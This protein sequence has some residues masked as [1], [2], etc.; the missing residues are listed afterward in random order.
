MASHSGKGNQKTTPNYRTVC[1]LTMF[2]ATITTSLALCKSLSSMTFGQR[3]SASSYVV[4]ARFSYKCETR[5]RG[6]CSTTH[7]RVS[8]GPSV[9]PMPFIDVVQQA[10]GSKRRLTDVFN[11]RRIHKTCHRCHKCPGSDE[12]SPMCRDGLG[13]VSPTSRNERADSEDVSPRQ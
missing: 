11:E 2:I 5:C 9:Y 12:V 6:T 7:K 1:P 8:G 10:P 3:L 13:C 4:R